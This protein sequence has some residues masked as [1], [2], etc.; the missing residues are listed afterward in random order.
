M[1]IRLV[2]L[3]ALSLIAR[4][5]DAQDVPA[6]RMPDSQSVL[7]ASSDETMSGMAA[8]SGPPD[9]SGVLDE[10]DPLREG[11][12]VDTYTFSVRANTEVTVTM[13]ATDFD[14][15]LVVRAPGGQEWSNDDFGGTQTS[16]VSFTPAARGTYTLLATS[17]GTDARGA[18]DVRVR[19]VAATVVSTVSG[20]LDYQDAQ[21]IKGEF[22]DTLT[23]RTPARGAFYIDLLALGFNGF[24]RA[25]APD[26]TR[27]TAQPPY[28]SQ[29]PVR[30]GPFEGGRGEWTVDVTS[31]GPNEVGAYDVRVIT[32]DD[33]Q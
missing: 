15:Y 6:A 31:Q 19:A 16:Q 22:Y 8:V 17:Y 5:A 14:T 12:P 30:M 13:T 21:Q 7:L 26:G 2:A 1:P 27:T 29:T 28:G 24:A 25:T 23:L 11:K 3:T 4:T 9:F 33:E 32:L 10:N 18:Y 20:R